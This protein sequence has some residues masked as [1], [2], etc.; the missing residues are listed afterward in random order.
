MGRKGGHRSERVV[1]RFS[2]VVY[3]YLTWDMLDRLGSRCKKE[4]MHL[5]HI[6]VGG[7]SKGEE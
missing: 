5:V 7:F 6:V 2:V 3:T 1:R 4:T